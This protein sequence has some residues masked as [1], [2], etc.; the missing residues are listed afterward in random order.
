MTSTST[1]RHDVDTS[2]LLSVILLS[3]QSEDRLGPTIDRLIRTLEEEAISFEII[4]VDDGSTDRS[5]ARAHALVEE[6][7]RIRAFDLS[8]NFGSPYSQFAGLS[9]AT[10]ACVVSVPDD[11]QSPP[12]LIVEM[13]RLWEQGHKIVVANR[14]SRSDGLVNDFFSNLYYW[15]MNKFS[16]VSFPPGGSD[17]FLAD[18]EIVDLL[19]T[20]I[21]PINTTPLL[22]VFR[23]GFSPHYLSYDRPPTSGKSRWTLEKKLKLAAD[24]FFG[25]SSYPLRLI[26]LLGFAIFVVCLLCVLVIIWAR[27]FTDYQ[28]FGLATNGWATSMVI[29]TMFNGLILLCIGI[30][31]EYIWRIHEEVKN[32]PG[33][34][35]RKPID[36]G[37]SSGIDDSREETGTE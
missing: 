33:Y 31:A 22:E 1:N 10:G 23:L 36:H 17:R 30:V 32:R 35:V 34:I 7:G 13:Y 26:T 27:I 5:S 16:D 19:N 18:R 28:V 11:L 29:M 2:K 37:E 25:S 15:L 6:D 4:I 14:R 8:R 9:L 12:E 3:Y 24:T 20:S 21:H